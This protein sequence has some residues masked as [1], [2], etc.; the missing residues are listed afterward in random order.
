MASEE[1][2]ENLTTAAIPDSRP[3]DIQLGFDV[4]R[5]WATSAQVFGNSHHY[6]IVFR[7]QTATMVAG[8]SMEMLIRNVGSVVMP[9]EIAVALRDALTLSIN[10]LAQDASK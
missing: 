3:V 4:D 10:G 2:A 9:T 1:T 6:L 7:E 8:G 5:I